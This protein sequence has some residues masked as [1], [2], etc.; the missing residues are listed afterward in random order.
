MAIQHF[1]TTK[2]S[3]NGQA[4]IPVDLRRALGIN[5]QSRALQ[6]FA[7]VEKREIRLIEGV[8]AEGLY[9]LLGRL[10][11]ESRAKT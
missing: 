11:A 5:E 9:E 4:G 2:I 1:G 8:D 10:N 7:D 3:P 6:V